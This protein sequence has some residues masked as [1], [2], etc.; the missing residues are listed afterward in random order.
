M[1]KQPNLFWCDQCAIYVSR[2]PE[3]LKAT[4]PPYICGS[5]G[6]TL[7]VADVK[8]PQPEYFCPNCQ[9]EI[10]APDA[11]PADGARAASCSHCGTV[12]Q[13]AAEVLGNPISL[14]FALTLVGVVARLLIRSGALERLEEL[15]VKTPTPVDNFAVQLARAVVIEAAKL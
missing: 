13:L 3:Q 9:L 6:R 5:C 8:P 15:A 7:E 4:P 11:I 12:L 14:P 10:R 1:S 2:S